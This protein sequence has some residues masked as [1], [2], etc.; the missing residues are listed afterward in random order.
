M[1]QE[2]ERV[3]S[4]KPEKSTA[5]RMNAKEIPS[6]LIAG[7]KDVLGQEAYLAPAKDNGEYKG[8]VLYSDETYVIQALATKNGRHNNAVIHRREDLDIQGDKLKDRNDIK[9]RNI[10]VYYKEGAEK[11]KLYPWSPEKE[12]AL[13][14]ARIAER[15]RLQKTGADKVISSAEKYAEANFKNPK[16][17]EAFLKGMAE[18]AKDA[19]PQK[20]APE[21]R[22]KTVPAQTREKSQQ[23]GMER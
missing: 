5:P 23:S 10:Q 19:F 21:Q 4:E 6:D 15:E 3:P 17:R 2:Q 8:K 9:G 12:A 1:A 20:A 22:Q 18:V 11:G 16:Q 13:K 7:T 14:E